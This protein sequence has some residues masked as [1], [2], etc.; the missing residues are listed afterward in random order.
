MKK[1]NKMIFLSLLVSVGLGLSVL[2][3]AMP[4]PVTIPGAKLGLSNVVILVTLVIFGF[5]ES[6]I[7]GVLKSIVLMF[8][9]G[10]PSSLIYSLSGAILASITMYI[11]YKYF[12]KVFSLI[13]VSIFGAVAHNIGQVSMASLMMYNSRIYSYLP[14]LLLMSLFTGYFV[15]LASMFITK[16]LEKSLKSYFV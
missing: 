10:S 4:L 13:G 8:V 15:G 9:T 2:E 1:L 3:S 7:V 16:N 11:V 6:F 12:S 14:I 5:K